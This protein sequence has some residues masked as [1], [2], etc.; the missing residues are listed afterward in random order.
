MPQN[1][2]LM[3]GDVVFRR[4]SGMLS[5]AV[6]A[7]DPDGNYSHVGIVADS[8]GKMMIIHAVPG[9]PD[10]EGDKDRVKMDTPEKFYNSIY[11]TIGAVCRTGNRK[12]ATKASWEAIRIYKKK[13]LFD[14]DYDRKDSTK[15]YCSELVERAYEKAGCKLTADSCGRV[16]NMP[17]IHTRCLLPSDIYKS[18]WLKPIKSF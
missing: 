16:L 13:T 4:G 12:M 6:M 10:Y 15:M 8:A 9:E 3:P 5:Y 11:A 17:G 18:A 2:R 14:H 7:A 1:I